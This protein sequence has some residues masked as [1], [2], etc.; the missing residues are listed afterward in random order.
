MNT[1]QR[2]GFFIVLLSA[3]G[4]A[5]LPI[6]GKNIYAV[7]DLQP[8]DV[9]TWRFIFATPL[10]WF[11]LMLRD[12]FM[13]P[14]KE[15]LPR[16]RL[17]LTGV[18]FAV[19]ALSAFS[20]LQYLDASVYVVIFFSYPAMIALIFLMLG[21]PLPLPAWL[22]LGLSLVGLLLTLPRGIT[23]DS[24]AGLGVVIA[25]A[26]ALFVAI[27][28]VVYSHI[29]RGYQSS[30]RASAYVISGA[31]LVFMLGLPFIDLQIPQNAATWLNLLFLAGFTTAMPII[32]LNIGIKMIGAAQSA[33]VSSIEP[34]LAMVLAMILLGETISPLQWLGVGCITAGVLLLEWRPR[35]ARWSQVP[36]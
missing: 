25:L 29:T 9:A 3:V 21:K 20:G 36:S 10:V 17:M 15:R 35:R 34:A 4:Y 5:F 33:I 28:F 6:I 18:I 13:T 8:L 14:H 26:N 12:Q 1:T 24:E 23:L 30:A 7:S 27:Y 32:T 19:A 16:P 22:A 11:L 31:F 2:V